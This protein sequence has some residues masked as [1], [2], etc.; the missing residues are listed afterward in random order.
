[1]KGYALRSVDDET[2]TE[3]EFSEEKLTGDQ[4]RVRITHSGVC[5]S[6]VHIREGGFSLGDGE[7]FS[8]EITGAE[9]PLVMGHEVVGV[10][11]ST[12]P[13][14]TVKEGEEVVVYTWLG[15][16]EC[17]T[18]ETGRENRCPNAKRALGIQRNGG[19]AEKVFLPHDKYL[20]PLDGIDPEWAATIGC[21]GIT[22]YSAAKQ[23][24]L[25][26]KD[27]PVLVIGAG[28]VGL[29]CIAS[30]KALGYTNISVIDRSGAN[31]ERALELGATRTLV[32][33]PETTP[34]DIWKFVGEQPHAVTDFVN[35]EETATLAFSS[36]AT[37]GTMVQ[38]GLFGGRFKVQTAV[39]AFQQVNIQ[40]S[41]VG[42][43]TELREVMQLAREGKFPRIPITTR[44]MSLESVIESLDAL[45]EGRSRGRVVLTN[46]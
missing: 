9:Y 22:A 32:S 36:L 20:V 42:S 37:G 15:C 28:G 6:D 12:G 1:M 2:I 45:K 31:F 43:L 41:Y 40:G 35:N 33:T 38:V 7:F 19:Y 4:V 44:E 30:L 14:A 8:N 25:K 24:N 26:S 13:D 5:H 34:Q 46:A 18:C 39:L 16:G 11:E 10:V 3:M 23:T 29:M 21:S 27:A 17:P